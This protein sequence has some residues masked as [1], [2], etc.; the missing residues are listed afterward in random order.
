MII[1]IKL[2]NFYS[3]REETVLDFTADVSSRRNKYNLEENFLEYNGDK[4]VNVIGLFGGN[5]A[6]K[7][8]IIKAIDFCRNLILHSHLVTNNT[9]FDFEPFKF[10]TNQPSEF[11]IDFVAEGVEYEYSF[12]ISEGRIVSESLYYYPKQRKARVFSREK[13]NLYSYGKGL[14]SRPTE[15]E[16]STGPQTL[17][18]SRGSSMNRAILQTIYRFFSQQVTT[19]ISSFNMGSLSRACFETNRNLMLKAFEVGDSDIIDIRWNDSS[20]GQPKLLSYHRENPSIAFDFE[21]EESEGTKRLFF[22]LLGLLNMSNLNCTV[23]LDEFDLKLHLLLAHF[24]LDLVRVCKGLQMVF[25]SHNPTLIDLTRLRPEQIV[26]V[27]KR[28]DGSSEFIPLSDYE[29]IEKIPD[30]MKAYLQG[31]FDGVPYIGNIKSLNLTEDN[32]GA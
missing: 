15:I 3:L 31:R 13:T 19:E 1:C 29:G 28:S 17:F 4:F 9:P 24:V 25:T 14:I 26:F 10:Q 11:Y 32:E 5:A 22:I 21:K 20:S 2:K 16:A 12:E 7:S 18:L 30:I 6:G 8:N 23:F 27:T